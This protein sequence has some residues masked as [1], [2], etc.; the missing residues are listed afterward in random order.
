VSTR[1]CLIFSGNFAHFLETRRGDRDFSFV[2][3][4]T[5]R[6]AFVVKAPLGFGLAH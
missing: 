5:T 6:A 1:E 4:R 2:A 3:G